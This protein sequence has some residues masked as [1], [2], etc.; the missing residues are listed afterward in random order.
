MGFIESFNKNN[1]IITL[2]KEDMESYISIISKN[3]IN[4]YFN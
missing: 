4:D 1:Y 3:S 2:G